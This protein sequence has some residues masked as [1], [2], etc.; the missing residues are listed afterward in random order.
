MFARLCALLVSL[1][2]TGC[3][4]RETVPDDIYASIRKCGMD[5]HIRLQKK[6]ERQF[7]V[8]YLDPNSD[9]AKVDCFL[10]EARRLRINLGFVGNEAIRTE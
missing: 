9:Y 8:V 6:G 4:P 3:A 1:L 7:R 10:G 5:G 2:V